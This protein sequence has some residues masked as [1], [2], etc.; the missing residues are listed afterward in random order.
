MALYGPE[1]N[2][3]VDDPVLCQL[4]PVEYASGD[5]YAKALCGSKI[6]LAMYSTMNAD[7]YAENA[8]KFLLRVR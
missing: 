3:V 7:V 2:G 5:E 8:L 1:W 4:W 6:A